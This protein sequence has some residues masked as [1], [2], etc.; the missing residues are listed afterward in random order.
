MGRKEVVI[1]DG[2]GKEERVSRKRRPLSEEEG[3]GGSG[4]VDPWGK[5]RGHRE[6]SVACVLDLLKESQ[7][8]WR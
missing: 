2:L 1:F 6:G 5:G 4:P 7:C 8:G 3:R